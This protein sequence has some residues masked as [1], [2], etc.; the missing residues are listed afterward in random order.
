MIKSVILAGPFVGSLEWELYRFAPYI[1]YLS[2]KSRKHKIIVLTRQDRFDLYGQYADILVPLHLTNQEDK[3][4]YQINYGLTTLD[5]QV[6][7]S[8]ALFF[9]NKYKHKYKISNHIYPDIQEPR[10]LLRWQYPRNQMNYNFI[11]RNKN[12]KIVSDI[13]KD[14]F[15]DLSKVEVNEYEIFSGLDNLNYS[16]IDYSRLNKKVRTEVNTSI[17]G[18]AICA[19]K[20]CKFVIGNIQSP[21][22]HLALLLKKPLISI[23]ERLS[24]DNIH[25]LNPLNTKIIQSNNFQKET[26][27]ENFIR[28]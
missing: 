19:I 5:N 8:I 23:G 16:F 26:I 24:D 14:V 20:K 4:E 6:Y 1:L 17:I 10:Y 3:E 28:E 22:S 21:I 15:V 9:Y 13:N 11:P 7:E 18:C 12:E 27:I 2:Y 25:L